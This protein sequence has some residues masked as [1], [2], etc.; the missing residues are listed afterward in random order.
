MT[1]SREIPQ[2]GYNYALTAMALLKRRVQ[3][4]INSARQRVMHGTW[5]ILL[6]VH[7]LRKTVP[8][9]FRLS[10]NNPVLHRKLDQICVR[11]KAEILHDAVFMKGHRA[12]R[13]VQNIRNL[14]HRFPFC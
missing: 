1:G 9:G 3:A 11:L 7:K 13:D 5:N 8:V 2:R 4:V 6:E 12:S 10:N 14:L